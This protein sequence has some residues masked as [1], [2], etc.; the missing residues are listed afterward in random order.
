[1]DNTIFL[2]GDKV[3]VTERIKESSWYIPSMGRY[4]GETMTIE[5]VPSRF[6]PE[7]GCV[8][9]LKEDGFNFNFD[10][11]GLELAKDDDYDGSNNVSDNDLLN[12]I[13]G[14]D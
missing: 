14:V 9:H 8:Y 12:F 5:E 6:S 1:M 3:L 7:F 10:N 13:G 4:I 11:I 2:I